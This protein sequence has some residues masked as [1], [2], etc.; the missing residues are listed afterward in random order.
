VQHFVRLYLPADFAQHT[1]VRAVVTYIKLFADF[2]KL[3]PREAPGNI[4]FNIAQFVVQS[5]LHQALEFYD[6]IKEEYRILESVVRIEIET[7]SPL[8]FTL[9]DEIY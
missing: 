2:R 7:Q 3:F 8:R 5:P 4:Q 9:C 6:S 1:A